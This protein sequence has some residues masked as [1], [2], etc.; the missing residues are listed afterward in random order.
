M[1]IFSKLGLP[2]VYAI[3][4]IL[5]IVTSCFFIIRSNTNK[6]VEI[7]LQAVELAAQKHTISALTDSLYITTSNLVYEK[8]VATRYREQGN[9]FCYKQVMAPKASIFSKKK[10]EWVEIPCTFND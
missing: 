8:S 4:G 10:F 3:I 7:K 6:S 2:N 5:V 9:R 1:S